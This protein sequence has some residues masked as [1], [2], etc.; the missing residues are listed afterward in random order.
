MRHGYGRYLD[1]IER[2]AP[3]INVAGL[4]GHCAT[5]FYVMGEHSE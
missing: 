1:P 3:M 4:V 5:R 2:T